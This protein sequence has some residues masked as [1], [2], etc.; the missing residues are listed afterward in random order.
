MKQNITRE[1]L[2]ELTPRQRKKLED[3]VFE[4]MLKTFEKFVPLFSIGHMINFLNWDDMEFYKLT[5]PSYYMRKKHPE[6]AI[7]R[8][9]V[10]DGDR[11][12][13]GKTFYGDSICDALW[14]AVK[15]VLKEK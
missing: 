15:E 3:W 14:E 13:A 8:W 9:G 10:M 7:Q 2:G 4:N 6:K 5:P 12:T 1:Q 11:E